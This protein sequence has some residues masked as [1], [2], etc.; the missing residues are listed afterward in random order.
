MSE[1]NDLL[2]QIK[3]DKDTNLLPSNLK[4]GVTVL[5]ISG[6]I[7]DQGNITIT[8]AETI[9]VTRTQGYH[10]GITVKPVNST[11]LYKTC[12]NYSNLILGVNREIPNEYTKLEYIESTGTQYIE[13]PF[14]GAPD[15]N[16]G[17]YNLIAEAQFISIN[18]YYS[19]EGIAAINGSNVSKAMF[20]YGIS[21][22][23]SNYVW[24]YNA[25]GS[26]NIL[27]S[28]RADTDRHIFEIVT[29]NEGINPG[30]YLDGLRIGTTVT[31]SSQ[32]YYYYN[33]YLF[34][35][36]GQDGFKGNSIRI[37]YYQIINTVTG[38]LLYDLIPAKKN[39]NNEIGMY[40]RINNIFYTNQGSGNFLY[41]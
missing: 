10:S 2:N 38:E 14:P 5:G 25:C 41:N 27:T 32:K 40:D 36:E 22:K 20:N 31:S 13:L 23:E 33:F 37:Y 16:N 3:Q 17:Y 24:S 9:D 34:G 26:E 8:P 6:S 4:Q 15:Y 19:L 11:R 30:F 39:I 12:E 29:S 35:Y 28:T 18:D 1:L 21:R 7:E